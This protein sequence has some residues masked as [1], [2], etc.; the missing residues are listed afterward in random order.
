MV[1]RS[2]IIVFIATTFFTGCLRTSERETIEQWGLFEL[3]MEGPS[4]GN[5]FLEVTFSALFSSGKEKVKVPGFYDGEGIYRIRFSPHSQGQWDYR[6]TSNLEE[7][8]GQSGRFICVSPGPE[9]H[10]PVEVVNTHYLQFADGTSYYA[11]GTTAYQWTSVAQ[12]IQSR[13]METL[14]GAPFNKIRMCVFPK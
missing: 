12:P 2:L 8:D 9:N 11:T 7:L 6:T 1:A 3:V 14:G 10:G 5:P 4:D 13:T